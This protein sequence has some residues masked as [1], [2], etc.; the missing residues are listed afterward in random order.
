MMNPALQLPSVSPFHQLLL[1]TFLVFS[2]ALPLRWLTKMSEE[3]SWQSSSR[4]PAKPWF[5]SRTICSLIQP[6]GFT[7]PK[8]SQVNTG[9]IA[10]LDDGMEGEDGALENG[11]NT[12]PAEFREESKLLPEAAN[13]SLS[14]SL[15]FI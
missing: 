9:G 13:I 12:S 6:A 4:C 11:T 2:A 3:A 10:P 8:V 14:V 5:R 7:S 15:R 1:A